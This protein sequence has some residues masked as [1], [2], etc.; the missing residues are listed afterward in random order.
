[1]NFMSMLSIICGT[2]HIC[3]ALMRKSFSVH[4][5]IERAA[6]DEWNREWQ[7]LYAGF[8]FQAEPG[9]PLEG[10]SRPKNETWSRK[11]FEWLQSSCLSYG[12]TIVP[13]IE[14]PG[15]SLA[16]TQWKP[17]LMINGAPVSALQ[18]LRFETLC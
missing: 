9:S 5:C 15:H 6:S 2:L 18:T 11:D 3:T 8:R 7:K 17:Q 10:L 13:E 14:S 16:I 1:M 12:V 4:L